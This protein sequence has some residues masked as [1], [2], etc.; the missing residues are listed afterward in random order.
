MNEFAPSANSNPFAPSRAGVYVLG[1]ATIVAGM[2]DL[3]WGEFDASHQPIGALGNIPG[4]MIFAYITA[5]WLILAGAAILWRRTARA[6]ALATAIVYLVFGLFWLPRFYTVPH[7]L[8]FRL[9]LLVG[10]LG[11]VFLQLMV[12]AGA[13][14]LYASLAPPASSWPQKVPVAARWTIGVGSLLCGVGHLIFVK[15]VAPMIPKWMPLGAPFW[16]V[17]SGVAFLLAGLAILSGILNLLAAYLLALMLLV[18]EVAL[19]PLVI[20]NPHAHIAWGANA[21][22]MAAVGA[23]WIFAASMASRH[24]KREP[25][26]QAASGLA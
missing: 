15:A 10:L 21:Y 17:I 5:A 22:N 1:L 18:F 2:L 3:I 25:A 16:V 13:L 9:T 8:G 4:R 7:M 24:A 19:V 6:G 23:V 12:V 26:I 20:A 11:Q 14:V